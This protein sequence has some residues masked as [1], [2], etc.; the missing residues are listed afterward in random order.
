MRNKS[1]GRYNPMHYT[2]EEIQKYGQNI[3]D[4]QL[5]QMSFQQTHHTVSTVGDHSMHVAFFA[6][7]IAQILN[8]MGMNIEIKSVV[9]AALCHDLGIIGERGKFG[10]KLCSIHPMLSVQ[11]ASFLLPD[12][13]YSESDA[14]RAHMFPATPLH[15]P[16]TIIGWIIS[17]AD[18]IAAIEEMT[19][20]GRMRKK[21]GITRLLFGMRV[22][23]AV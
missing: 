17:V 21:D 16:H 9:R 5:F 8:R 10:R 19:M 18:K 2:N 13:N 20:P 1:E 14:I 11:R 6:V 7:C 15:H 4:S 23:T 3:F 22:T 12:L